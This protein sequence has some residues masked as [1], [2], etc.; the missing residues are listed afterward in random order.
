[1]ATGNK[2]AL[3]PEVDRDVW[4]LQPHAFGIALADNVL[5]GLF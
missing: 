4:Q 3:P 2:L 5:A 1:M